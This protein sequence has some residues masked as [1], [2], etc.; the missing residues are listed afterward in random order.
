MD[1]LTYEILLYKNRA[2][3]IFQPAEKAEGHIKKLLSDKFK[4]L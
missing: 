4:Q 1:K 3:L 2:V